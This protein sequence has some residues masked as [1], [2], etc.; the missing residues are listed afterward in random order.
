MVKRQQK[1]YRKQGP[2]KTTEEANDFCGASNDV[3]L[4]NL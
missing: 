3:Q 4:V 2:I 1:Q